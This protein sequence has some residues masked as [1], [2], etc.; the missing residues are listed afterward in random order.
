MSWSLHQ[1]SHSHSL[2]A[3]PLATPTCSISS[4]VLP[5]KSAGPYLPSVAGDKG[6]G[7]FSY[8]H[9][10]R[11]IDS[12]ELRMEGGN[13]SLFHSTTSQANIR[14]SS[15]TCH[16]RQG[17]K[18]GEGISPSLARTVLPCSHPLGWLSHPPGHQGQLYC[19]AAG[20]GQVQL[21]CSNDL[22]AS[23]PACCRCYGVRRDYLYLAYV[24]SCQTSGGVSSP[25][26]L[27]PGSGAGL[28]FPNAAAG[29]GQGKTS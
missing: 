8:S 1:F 18:V 10:P 17:M 12:E 2:W 22:R 5:R 21:F 24:T 9:D 27:P 20:E 11:D 23:S 13:L 29:E 28:V 3:S 26:P 15:P 25:V 19:A 7:Q 6:Y 4:T 16:R 14:A